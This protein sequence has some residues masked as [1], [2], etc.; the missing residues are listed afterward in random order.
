MYRMRR[1]LPPNPPEEEPEEPEAMIFS[2][3]KNLW[4]KTKDTLK[5]G[6]LWIKTY[7]HN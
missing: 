2:V 1:M 5:G 4:V 3:I 6:V 7:L